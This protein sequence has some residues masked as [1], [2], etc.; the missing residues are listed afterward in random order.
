MA[1]KRLY[2]NNTVPGK[3]FFPAEGYLIMK[4]KFDV[5]FYNDLV[6]EMKGLRGFQRIINDK[7]DIDGSKRLQRLC[8]PSEKRERPLKTIIDEVREKAK[9]FGDGWIINKVSMLYSK[10]NCPRQLPHRDFKNVEDG[11]LAAVAIVAVEEETFIIVK[12]KKEWIP[13]G[14]M[15]LMRGDLFHARSEYKKDNLRLH[16]NLGIDENHYADNEIF[17]K[18]RRKCN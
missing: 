1:T 18:K 13:K 16:F 7:K 6:I 10:K 2:R 15:F 12:N 11:K 5:D 14:F 9:H 17:L 4:L 3:K 8:L